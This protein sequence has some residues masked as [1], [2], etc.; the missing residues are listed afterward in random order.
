MAL[1]PEAQQPPSFRILV[2]E[3]DPASQALVRRGLLREFPAC[4]ITMA[5]DGERALSLLLPPDGA[6][7]PCSP[8]LLLLDLNVPCLDGRK[9]LDR[10]R[11][12]QRTADLPVVIVSTSTHPKDVED[13]RA[14]GANA[15]VQKPGS[16]AEFFAELG[17]QIRLCLPSLTEGNG[18]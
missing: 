12:D 15:Y 5:C 9:I 3:D 2:V 16:V 14:L 7:A 6:V 1:G 11:A 13:C 10:V 4:E 8:D 18:S 17:V